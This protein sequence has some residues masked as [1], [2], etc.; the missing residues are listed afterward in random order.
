[1][2]IS[3]TNT[4]LV[5]TEHAMYHA[6]S[7]AMARSRSALVAARCAGK[8][9]GGGEGCEEAANHVEGDTVGCVQGDVCVVCMGERGC[10]FLCGGVDRSG[11]GSGGIGAR[12]QRRFRELGCAGMWT[13]E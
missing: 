2:S 11:T 8:A 5:T 7:D 13:V 1:M 10:S 12:L 4:S 9:K 3:A 6:P